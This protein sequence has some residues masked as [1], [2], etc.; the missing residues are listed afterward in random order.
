MTVGPPVVD[1]ADRRPGPGLTDS[2]Q[3]RFALDARYRLI[4]LHLLRSHALACRECGD[5]VELLEELVGPDPA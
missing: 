2:E 3:H 4:R 1:A 5:L